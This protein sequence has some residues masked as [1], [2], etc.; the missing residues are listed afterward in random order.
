MVESTKIAPCELHYEMRVLPPC[1]RL[2]GIPEINVINA[3]NA[4]DQ[5]PEVILCRSPWNRGG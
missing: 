2:Y 1:A 5:I 4:I 3:I